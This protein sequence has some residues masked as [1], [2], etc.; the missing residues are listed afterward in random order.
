MKKRIRKKMYKRNLVTCA[1]CKNHTEFYKLD[2]GEK[3]C[4]PCF[5]EIVGLDEE[6][7]YRYV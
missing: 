5:G 1:G 3:Y 4:P 6:E 7:I 2:E